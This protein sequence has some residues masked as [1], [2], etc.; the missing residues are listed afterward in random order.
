MACVGY[1]SWTHINHY[2]FEAYSQ[3][4][5][6][7][8][9]A[10]APLVREVRSEIPYALA[11][12]AKT[13]RSIA[14][15]WVSGVS[16][17]KLAQLKPH[18]VD[19]NVDSGAKSE[20]YTANGQVV[21]ALQ[22]LAAREAK[23]GDWN[24]S[25]SDSLLAAKTANCVSEF[26]LASFARGNQYL[27]RSLSIV[28]GDM[29]HLSLAAKREAAQGL[30]SISLQDAQ[31]SSLAI[32]ERNLYVQHTIERSGNAKE[33]E[34]FTKEITTQDLS[35]ANFL[36]GRGRLRSLASQSGNED[37]LMLVANVAFAYESV[38]EVNSRVQGLMSAMKA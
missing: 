13:A 31:V 10:Y 9:S 19:D 20:I 30:A 6:D 17:G 23:A 36:S 35:S 11:P 8:V 3:A 22:T 7:Q 15:E 34:R 38:N 33:A 21:A 37:E 5:N 4:Q 29:P 26:D 28:R 2:Q 12:T 16:R 32:L 14:N 25:T 1:S 24:E 27:L 18:F